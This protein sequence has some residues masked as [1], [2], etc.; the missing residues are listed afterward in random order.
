MLTRQNRDDIVSCMSNAIYIPISR[1]AEFIPGSPGRRTISRYINRGLNGV[2]LR[3][4]RS[5]GRG[6]T[7]EQWINDFL[8]GAASQAVHG[9]PVTTQERQQN[10][11]DIEW[12][13]KRAY[14]VKFPDP[15]PGPGL[16][17]SGSSSRMLPGVPSGGPSPDRQ[18]TNN[19]IKTTQGRVAAAEVSTPETVTTR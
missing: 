14:G 12:R 7:T 3:V 15:L 5:A 13:M 16:R 2:R 6:F 8:T 11:A 4:V 18:R 17:S 1:V 9:V 10:R 19:R